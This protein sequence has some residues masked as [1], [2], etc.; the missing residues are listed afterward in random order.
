MKERDKYGSPFDRAGR[1][2]GAGLTVAV[3]M[4]LLTFGISSGLRYIYPPPAEQ[5]ILIDFEAEEE[6]K[7]IQTAVGVEPRAEKAD[8]EKE[9]TLVQKSE[10]PVAAPEAENLGDESTVGTEGD[11]EVPEPPRPKPIDKRAL[12]SSNRHRKDTLAQQV[13]DKV[14][15]ALTSGH[16][17][18]NTEIGN[19]EGTPSAKLEG[20]TTMGNLPIPSYEVAKAGTVVV[21]ILVDQQ[22][23]VI[24]AY[25]GAKGTTVNDARM[26][27]AAK[28]AAL[29]AK[30]NV[31]ASAPAVQEGTISYVFILK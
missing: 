8:P 27:Q 17:K 20:R 14:S 13:A 31:S 28:E 26:W 9:V 21:R 29:K 23:N 4:L 3:H 15:D 19:H 12:F 1:K 5:G 24:D 25:P 18:G 11:V 22:G 30:F 10:A 16:P 2:I 6:I 7:P